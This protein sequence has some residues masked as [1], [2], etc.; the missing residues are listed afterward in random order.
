MSEATLA[1]IQLD[2]CKSKLNIISCHELRC[3]ALSNYRKTLNLISLYF[4][5]YLLKCTKMEA[6]LAIY[7]KSQPLSTACES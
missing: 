1:K 4:F 6:E 2:V 5:L 3:K 7:T